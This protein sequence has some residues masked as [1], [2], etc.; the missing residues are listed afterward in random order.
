MLKLRHPVLRLTPTTLLFFLL[1]A[2][3]CSSETPGENEGDLSATESQG[4]DFGQEGGTNPA[5]N[6]GT[7]PIDTG[8]DD[9]GGEST[10]IEEGTAP[11]EEENDPV[12]EESDPLEEE[13]DP[14][15]EEVDPIEEEAEEPIE[16]PAVEAV[17]A[18]SIVTNSLPGS[19]ACGAT[20]GTSRKITKI[21]LIIRAILSPPTRSRMMAGG[22]AMIP[23]AKKPCSARSTISCV[24]LVTSAQA[25]EKAM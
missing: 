2:L 3:G 4:T 18:A 8:S 1:F 25:S 21:R 15:E 23:A 16:E 12:E 6:E 13:A 22:K 7:E 20:A 19:L 10:P 24:K 5:G 14:I 17:N 9:T 11:I